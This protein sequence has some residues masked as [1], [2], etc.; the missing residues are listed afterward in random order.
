MIVIVEKQAEKLK[1][2][3][4]KVEWGMRDKEWR[5]NIEKIDFKLFGG[6]AFRLTDEWTNRHLWLLSCFHNRKYKYWKI[7]EY[8]KKVSTLTI[9]TVENISLMMHLCPTFGI[10]SNLAIISYF[11]EY[12]WLKIKQLSK[13]FLQMVLH[14]I[15][16]TYFGLHLVHLWCKYIRYFMNRQKK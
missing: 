3:K 13:F 8:F 1:N 15:L 12:H 5:M 4:M 2:W 6:F 16:C 14:Q 7:S 9:I 11:L 10:V